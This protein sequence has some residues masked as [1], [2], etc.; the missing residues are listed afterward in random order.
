MRF[1]ATRRRERQE[2][3][4]LSSRAEPTSISMKH[5]GLKIAFCSVAR[6]DGKRT[7][8]DSDER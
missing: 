4:P 2:A 3:E 1:A 6:T 7:V 8:A 5:A